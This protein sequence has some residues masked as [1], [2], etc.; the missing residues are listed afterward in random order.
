M[1]KNYLKIA[2]RNLLKNKASSVINIGGLA[3][4]MAVAMLIGLWMYTELSFDKNIPNH[5]RIAQVMQNQWINNET[6]TWNSQ[7]YP[8][9]A[10]LRNEYGGDFKHVIM[11]S[12]AG[13]HIFSIG[14]KNLKVSGN[15]MEPG[16]TD[17]LSL[18]M[19]KGSRNGLN[20]LNSILLSQSAVKAIFGDADAMNKIIK[21]DHDDVLTVKV[22]GVYEDLPKNSSFG[23]LAFISPWQLLVK[24]QHYDTRFNNPWGAS[25]FQTLV[26]VADNADMNKVSDKIKDIKMKDLVRTHNS[27]ARFKPV[28]FLHPMNKWHLYNDFKNGVNTGGDIQ[29]VWLFGIIGVFVLLLACINFMNLSTARSEKRA[30]EVGIRKSV[31]SGR[32]QLITQFYCESLVIAAFSFLFAIL[33]VQLCLPFFNEVAAKKISMPWGSTLFWL[34][35]IGFTLFTGL[36]AGSYPALYL[37]SF[38]P[39]KVLKG[40]FRAGRLASVPR[41]VL[42]VL[43]FTVSIVL[44]IGTIV[45]FN[46][47]QYAKNR[48]IGYNVNALMVVPLQTD[49]IAKKSDAVR[50]DLMTSGVVA[51]VSMSETRI[52]DG[53]TTNGGFMWQGKDPALQENFKS[54]GISPEFGKTVKWEI[55]EG[56]DFDPAIPSDS[57]AFIINEACVKYLGFKNPIGQTI[58][59]IGSG[60]YKII[61]VVKDMITESAYRPVEQTFFYLRKGLTNVD[62]RLN[63]NTSAHEAI[64]KIGAIFKKYDPSTPFEYNF[65]DDDYAKKF[66][67]E[68]RVGKLASSFA[69]L[70][71]FISC[72]G[73][74]GMAS[75]TA[76]QRVKEI[77]VRKVLGASVFNLWRLLSKDFIGLIVISLL[78]ASPIAYYFMH[79]W[80]QNYQYRS[81]MGWWIFAVTAAGALL[82]TVLTVS[83]Q[84]IKAALANPVKSLKAE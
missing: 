20:D 56:R 23:D 72:L 77:G 47:V 38:N 4:G 3:V 37:S 57:S 49:F 43:Q 46:Q 68:V 53:N 36:I 84:S 82:I 17:M 66:D 19:I 69:S 51:S 21:I 26:Q 60:K 16:I 55:K 83:Y 59:W 9:G 35:G 44:I 33:F 2:W 71:I 65:A 31:G 34:V 80:L 11:S 30:K 40:T 32:S 48:P 74:F 64:D 10:M 8:L 63:P 62:I 45:V 25:W 13:G 54:L 67:T 75:F 52:T 18:K 28:I 29:Y 41:K 61:G 7:A 73:L 24:D 14:D 1:I 6:D 81:A 42:V 22:T 79:S 12:W 27:D 78:I 58:T 39:V 70:A 15:F 76:E 50:N 5:D